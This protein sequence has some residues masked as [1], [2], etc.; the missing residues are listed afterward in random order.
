[1][2]LPRGMVKVELIPQ[3][4]T[5]GALALSIY[6]CRT[7]GEERSYYGSLRIVH[8]TYVMQDEVGDLLLHCGSHMCCHV[9]RVWHTGL[10]R[11]IVATLIATIFLLC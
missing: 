8:R 5:G 11:I 7:F 10:V 1:M 3:H 4:C 6:Q 9:T 2:I